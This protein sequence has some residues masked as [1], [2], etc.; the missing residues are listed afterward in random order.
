MATKPKQPG[1]QGRGKAKA[2]PAA[3]KPMGRP[4][5][6][7]DFNIFEGRCRTQCT[8]I[9]IAAI[10]DVDVDTLNAR[11]KEHYGETFS[12]V[13]KKKSAAG[14]MSLRRAQ[15]KLAEAGNPTMLIWLGKQYLNQKDRMEVEN[16]PI[17]WAQVPDDVLDAYTDGKINEDAVRRAIVAGTRTR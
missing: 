9:E 6:E 17:D 1:K 14:K 8:E 10:F 11:I 16:D 13:Y 15:I 12:D 5:K 3:P 2:Q 7:I 4:R